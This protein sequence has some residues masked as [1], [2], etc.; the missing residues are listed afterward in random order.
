MPVDKEAVRKAFDEFETDNYVDA[1]EILAKQIKKVKNEYIKT[2]LELKG[3]VEE[4]EEEETEEE[5][6]ED[7]KDED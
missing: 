5:P 1:E 6:E 4:P 7:D 3:D 2:E